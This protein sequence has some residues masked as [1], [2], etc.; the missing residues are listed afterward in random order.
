MSDVAVVKNNGLMDSDILNPQI[1]IEDRLN[2]A[3]DVA[4]K[5][6]QAIQQLGLIQKI[7]GKDY[8]TVSGWSTL[9]TMIG[10]HVENIQVE[11][12]PTIKS[13]GFGCFTI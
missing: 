3:G 6:K 1:S 9:G 5:F 10:I 12:F 13:N 8:V 4:A 7:K 2:L 11:P